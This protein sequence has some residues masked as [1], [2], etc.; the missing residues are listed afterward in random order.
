MF[1]DCLYNL[2]YCLVGSIGSIII[3]KSLLKKSVSKNI[4]I[5][6][7]YILINAFTYQEN[8]APLQTF[9]KCLALTLAIK[10]LFD[11]KISN[12]FITSVVIM[13][14]LIIS[15]IILFLNPFFLDNL[16]IIRSNIVL[17][18]LTNFCGILIGYLISKINFINKPI[19]KFLLKFEEN[20]KKN[21]IIISIILM[22]SL[23]FFF[24]LVF[25]ERNAEVNNMVLFVFVITLCILFYIQL[26]EK[27]KYNSLIIKYN[28]LLE[29]AYTYEEE[30]EKGNLIRHEHKNQLAVI[31]GLTK[32]KKVNNY[33]DDLLKNSKEDNNSNITGINNL[34]KGG[35]RGLVYY[36]LCV[37]K[38]KK[39]DY[40]LD[41]SKNI[42]NKLSKLG[43]DEKKILSYLLGVFIDN[44]IE[45]CEGNR[46]A[47]IS[48]E[49]YNINKEIKIIISNSIINKIDLKKIGK[50]GFTTKGKGHG[51]GLYLVT[52]LLKGN[53]KIKINTKI[54][55]DYF[56]QEIRI[57]INKKD[58]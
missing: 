12:A 43:D 25:L 2:P 24:Y 14:I 19:N 44:A 23:A 48:I 51:N 54:I 47:N 41:V 42:K 30:I 18:T 39:I 15:E 56:I 3:A 35:I 1:M 9:L 58:V 52:N 29:N 38:K 16:M 7:F 28:N 32:N 33:I 50:K 5:I 34:P 10:K 27:N 37:I 21:E 31:R 46:K 11:V 53:D 22:S 57:N 20:T 13:I 55:N 26:N 4:I 17:F 8:Y 6:L 49:I 45:A 40:S 36:K